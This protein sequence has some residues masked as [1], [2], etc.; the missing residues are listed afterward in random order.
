MA[1]N[2]T[3]EDGNGVSK[4]NPDGVRGENGE[5]SKDKLID[6]ADHQRAI[7]DLHKYKSNWREA[8]AK[9]DELTGQIDQINQKD[10]ENKEDF[11]S[12]YESE[13]EKRQQVE[14]RYGSL[15]TNLEV[16]KKHDAV[17]AEL[18]SAGL[19]KGADDLINDEVLEKVQIE[20]TDQGRM[21]VHGADHAADLFKQKYPFAFQ[22]RNETNVNPGGGRGKPPSETK[23]DGAKL[24][25]L[26]L[27]CRR[28]G[29]MAPLKAAYDEYRKQR[30]A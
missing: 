1:D 11:K 26:E 4:E 18:L 27:E 3:Q 24:R 22:Q 21:I 8:Q 14:Q 20:Y 12:L 25:K 28:K 17:R 23:W 15:K 19:Q 7:D 9:I 5:G 13:R 30:M 10:L 16:T 6:P 29:D 2:E